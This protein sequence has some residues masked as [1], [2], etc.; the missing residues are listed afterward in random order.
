MPGSTANWIAVDWG[1]SRLRAWIMDD[2]NEVIQSLSSGEGMGALAQQEFEA[3]LL[4]L[5]E[6]YLR[7]DGLTTVIACGMVGARQGWIEAEYLQIPCPPPGIANATVAPTTD[8][9]LAVKILPGV[10]QQ[11]PADV[12]RGE[13]TQIAG[14]IKSNPGFRGTICLPGTHA[15]W[16][17]IVDGSLQKFTTLMSGEM[18]AAISK[19]T[20]LRHSVDEGWDESAFTEAVCESF[21]APERLSA[22]LFGIRAKGLLSGLSASQA[23]AR[24]SGLLLGLELAGTKD[25]RSGDPILLIGAEQLCR[26]Y[27]AALEAIDCASE[28][29]EGDKLVLEGLK[30]AYLAQ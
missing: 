30:A 9:R 11:D 8:K 20:V 26:R 19:H 1:T 2:R 15:K 27:Q 23:T 18:F 29:I 13:E 22:S 25:Y 6:P 24:L 3:A 14:F 7:A 12:M 17:A 5:I 10:C 28:T 21:A 16:V 4:R